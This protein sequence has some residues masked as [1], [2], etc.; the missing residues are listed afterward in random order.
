MFQLL[1]ERS[2][3][4]LRLGT[5]SLARRSL[6]V[7]IQISNAGLDVTATKHCVL[8]A[9]AKPVRPAPLSN[10]L[11]TCNA[12]SFEGYSKIPYAWRRFGWT[13]TGS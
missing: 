10:N 3:Q 13:E 6:S 4:V 12:H 8:Y 7:I 5:S 2:L 1:A 9:I 11:A